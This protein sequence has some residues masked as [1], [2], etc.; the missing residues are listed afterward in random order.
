[1]QVH[2]EPHQ[3][4][5]PDRHGLDTPRG[6][7]S[8][9]ALALRWCVLPSGDGESEITMSYQR[10]LWQLHGNSPTDPARWAQGL[11]LHI[12]HSPLTTIAM[13]I[14]D[15]QRSY[16]V[17]HGCGRCLHNDCAIGCPTSLFRRLVQ[18]ALPNGQLQPVPQPQGLAIRPYTNAA[19]CWPL[20]H[21]QPLTAD[22]LESWPEARLTLHWAH[23]MRSPCVGGL[24]MTTADSPVIRLH[25]QGWRALPLPRPSLRMLNRQVLP[26]PI[27]GV[28]WPGDPFV[29]FSQPNADDGDS[30]GASAADAEHPANSVARQAAPHAVDAAAQPE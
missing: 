5:V 12:R 8:P 3:L 26:L 18:A 4:L 16:I 19:L 14:G 10:M 7:R 2:R 1:M 25:E 28:P 13:R 9:T 17:L 30:T 20:P 15:A 21:A 11:A 24:L 27:P 6:N 23:A 29:L 22:M